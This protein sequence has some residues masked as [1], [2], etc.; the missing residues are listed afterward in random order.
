MIC[1]SVKRLGFMSIPQRVMD[2]THFWRRFRGSGQTYNYSR[3]ATG[4]RAIERGYTALIGWAVMRPLDTRE[5]QQNS[6]QPVQAYYS[7]RVARPAGEVAR[8]N[9]IRLTP[10]MP[11]QVFIRTHERTPLQYLLKPLQEQ[12]ARTFRER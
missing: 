8:L 6:G 10:G 3:L 5:Q 7:V 9:D 2:S 1:S 11:A 12:I 4:G